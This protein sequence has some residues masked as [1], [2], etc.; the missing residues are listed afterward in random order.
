MKRLLQAL[1]VLAWLMFFAFAG[2]V[3][4]LRFWLLPDIEHYRGDIVAAVTR[5]VGLPV[6]IG[7]IEAGWLGLRPQLSFYDVRVYDSAGHEALILPV[8]DNVIAWRSIVRG[9]LRLHSLA[10]DS[11]RLNVRRDAAGE[12]YVAGLKLASASRGD[13]RLSDWILDQAEITIHNAQIEWLDEKRRALPLTLSQLDF[14]L[15]NRGAE[16][17]V[18][19]SA[20]PPPELGAALEVRAELAGRTL[21][22]LS[23]WNGKLYLEL[24]ATDL[25][26]W[27]AWVDYPVDVQRGEGALR[28][29]ATLQNGQPRDATLDLALSRVVARLAKDL[30]PLE[31]A[32]LRGR[33]HAE[34][35]E[36]GYDLAGRQLALAS[37]QGPGLSPTDFRVQW[38]PAGKAPE[39]GA[40]SASAL[41]LAPMA[42]LAE[43]LPFPAQLRKTLSELAPRGRLLDARVEWTGPPNAPTQYSAKT[44]FSE[45]ALRPWEKVP[46]FT[47]FSGAVDATES[48]GTLQIASRGTEIALP[49]VLADPLRFDTLSGQLDWQ[50]RGDQIALTLASLSFANEHLEGKANGTYATAPAGPGVVDFSAQLARA[51]GRFTARYLPLPEIMGPATHEWVANAV[52][53]GQASDVRFRLKGDLRDFPFVDPAKGQFLVAAHVEKGTLDYVPGWPLVNDIDA[54]LLFERDRMEIL[55]RSGTILGAKLANVRV[56]IPK[57]ARGAHLLIDGRAEG[58]TGEFLRYLDATP[59][60][61]MIGGFTDGM[62]ADGRGKLELKLD[63]PLATPRATQVAGDYEF[64]GDTLRLHSQVPPIERVTG[65]VAFTES[66]AT[67]QNVHARAFG[68]ALTVTGGSRAGA[69]VEVVARGDATVAALQALAGTPLLRYVSGSAG[70][71]ATVVAREG[72]VRVI[73]ESSLRGVASALPPPLT[74]GVSDALPLRVEVLPAEAGTRDRISASLGTIAAAEFLRRKQ[75]EAMVVQRA[76]IWLTPGKEP[77]RLPE[78]PGV[79]VYGTLGAFDADRWRSFF[80]SAEGGGGAGAAAGGAAGLENALSFDVKI[81][82]LDVYGK[83][84]H[85]LALRAGADAAGWSATVNGQ[86]IAG[87]LSYRSER[88]GQLMARLTNFAMPEDTPGT[89]PA[90]PAKATKELPSVDLSADHFMYRGKQFGRVEVIAQR[91]G[92]TWRIERAAMV[93]PDASVTVHGVWQTA[94][95]SSTTLDLQL[96]SSDAGAFLGRIGYPNLVRGAKAHMQGSVSWAGDPTAPDYPSLSGDIAMQAEDGQFLEIEPGLGKLVSLMSLQ[97]LPRRLSLDFRDVFSKGFQFDRIASSAHIERGVMTVKEFNMRGSAAQVAM[98]GQVDLARETQNLKVRVIPSLGDSAS[99]VLAFLNPLLVFPAQIA[100]KILKDPLGHIFAFDYSITG[101]WSDPKV[102]KTRVAADP[103]SPNPGAGQ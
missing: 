13:S 51:D 9:D 34:Q 96:E 45:L 93:N 2:T 89:K 103:V 25:S 97:A 65:K 78:R 33:L 37:R 87:D 39:H 31:L 27:R 94:P 23:A 98:T 79:L 30:P 50:R 85:E 56:S 83:R 48:K 59:V 47:G 32:S 95:A 42:Q 14:R 24:G 53:Q 46:G 67:V 7:A 70:Y 69:G 5:A 76:A 63:I 74:K 91:A 52:K 43:S 11:P 60:R 6:K 26:G 100:Q 82:V 4:A 57:L 41:D 10:I 40:A 36:G 49:R 1:E 88:G 12:L 19:L 28:I 55:G 29:W 92:D 101:S 80:A 18:G 8:V 84:L 16:H 90:E 102:A 86:E 15:R 81:G 73:V 61:G 38:R 54:Q 21:A 99:T 66:G 68:G 75:G 71:T 72:R 17:L 20:R 77:L 64:L 3:L 44:R 22:D 62:S 35:H 58:P